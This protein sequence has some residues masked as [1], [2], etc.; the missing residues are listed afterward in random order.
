MVDIR[1]N[2]YIRH[3][4]GPWRITNNFCMITIIESY[5]RHSLVIEEVVI[6]SEYMN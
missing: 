6:S 5:V 3:C 1:E 4:P 2:R